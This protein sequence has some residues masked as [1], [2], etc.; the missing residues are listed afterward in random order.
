MAPC[1]IFLSNKALD[2][3]IH[4]FALRSYLFLLNLDS[5]TC[6][7]ICFLSMAIIQHPVNAEFIRACAIIG[8]PKHIL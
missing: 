5:A 6:L 8:A 7:P 3:D 4:F 2:Q 1:I